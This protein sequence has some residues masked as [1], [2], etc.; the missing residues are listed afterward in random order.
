MHHLLISIISEHLT[1]LMRMNYF[2]AKQMQGYRVI[3]NTFLKYDVYIVLDELCDKINLTHVAM[4][5]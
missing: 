1:S 3:A 5:S 4:L 2:L